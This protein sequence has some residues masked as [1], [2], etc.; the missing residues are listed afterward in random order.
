MQCPSPLVLL[1]VVFL[2]RLIFSSDKAVRV[3]PYRPMGPYP[4][5]A[6][7]QTQPNIHIEATFYMG[8]P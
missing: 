8:F 5:Y 1:H 7:Q 2:L 6:L 4:L 3:G